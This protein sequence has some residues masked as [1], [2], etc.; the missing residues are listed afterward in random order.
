MTK[1]TKFT[2]AALTAL[3]LPAYAMGAGAA[4]MDANGDGL[5][6]VTEVQAVYPDVTA[7]QYS[8]M[9]LNADGALDEAEVQTA[10]EAGMLPASEEG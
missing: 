1:T 9:D 7:E 2:V 3:C 6:S 5:L 10:Q 8:A 4:E